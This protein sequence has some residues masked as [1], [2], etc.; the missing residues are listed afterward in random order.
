LKLCARLG[1]P[2]SRKSSTPTEQRNAT[3]MRRPT[4]VDCLGIAWS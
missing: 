3:L 2:R 4:G 1:Y